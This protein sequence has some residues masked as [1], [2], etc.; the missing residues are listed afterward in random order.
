M[1]KCR[2][3]NVPVAAN[4]TPACGKCLLSCMMPSTSVK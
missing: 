1:D 4:S 2:Y 3:L